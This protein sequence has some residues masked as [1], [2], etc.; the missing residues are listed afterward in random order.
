MS[1]ES[2]MFRCWVLKTFWCRDS[3][4]C[5]FH[6]SPLHTI[7]RMGKNNQRPVYKINNGEVVEEFESLVLAGKSVNR[8]HANIRQSILKG[9]KCAGYNWKF[10][11]FAEEGEVWKKHPTLD[12]ECSSRGRMRTATGK[13]RVGS[14][15][16]PSGYRNTQIGGKTYYVSRLIAETFI[17]NPENKRTVDHINRDRSDNRV[18]NL[19][20]YTYI[21]QQTNKSK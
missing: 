11:E 16:K 15:K 17:E 14:I 10:K 1:W 2:I 20:W 3:F 13:I 6:F 4:N 18:E 21:E 12:I 7:Y 9:Y 8:T 5:Q 19:R